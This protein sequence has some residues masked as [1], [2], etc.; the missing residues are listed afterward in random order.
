GGRTELDVEA[1]AGMHSEDHDPATGGVVANHLDQ[2]DSVLLLGEGDVFGEVV[3]PDRGVGEVEVLLVADRVHD[4]RGA[5]GFGG[6]GQQAGYAVGQQVGALVLGPHQRRWDRFGFVAV[7][8]GP[9][10]LC[11][12]H[13]VLGDHGDL[14]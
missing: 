9:R 11:G 2:R 7:V 8:V 10:V 4:L 14:T 3:A 13:R 12:G 5:L 1:A 6:V